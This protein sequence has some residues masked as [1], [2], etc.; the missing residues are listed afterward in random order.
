MNH[1]ST[2]QQRPATKRA[3]A[4]RMGELFESRRIVALM[5]AVVRLRLPD[6]LSTPRTVAELA[7]LTT[8]HEDSLRRLLNAGVVSG[9]FEEV[10]DD[11]YGLTDLSRL[12]AADA[13][14]SMRALALMDS[15]EFLVR[16]WA[17][18][19]ASVRTGRPATHEVYGQSVWDYFAQ[20]PA[21]A[22][23]FN[24][25]MTFISGSQAPALATCYPFS[26]F[27]HVVDVGGG[28][29]ALLSEIL[30]AHHALKGTLFDLPSVIEQA[31]ASGF[32]AELGERCTLSG[33]SFFEAVPTADAYILRHILHDWDDEICSRILSVCRSA[34]TAAASLLIIENVLAARA[35]DRPTGAA[36]LDIDML[37]LA[38]GRERTEDDWR[39]LL[40]SNG[41]ALRSIHATPVGVSILECEV[42]A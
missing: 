20:N 26:K 24:G 18:L 29:G 3:P 11:R 5:G 23:L 22:A 32:F 39:R 14:G 6:N 41:L 12:L 25:A 15:A 40:A 2:R 34:M 30:R 21:D 27:T 19:D 35:S 37:V 28:C 17:N 8:S 31:R 10:G 33:G 42:S 36:L 4:E 13:A 9:L 1:E 38:G 16:S 7:A